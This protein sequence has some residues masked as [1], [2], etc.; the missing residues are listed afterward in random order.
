VEVNY[1]P[2]HVG[3]YAA[4][5]AHLEPL[6]DL[7]YRRMLDLYYRTEKALPCEVSAIARLT[8]LS[9]HAATIRDVLNEFFTASDDG[10]HSK[11]AD[12]ELSEM[13]SKQEQQATKDEHEAERLRRHRARRA[14]MFEAL[15]AVGVIPAWDVAIKELQRLFDT[16]CN[17]PATRTSP[18]PATD[19]QRLSLP[20]PTPTPEVKTARKRAASPAVECPEG[21]DAQVWADWL[22]L[23][24]AKRAP[25]TATTI[26]G[27]TTEAAKA[28]M[29]LDAFLRVWCRRGSQGLE[30]EWLKPNERGS[31]TGVTVQV[32]PQ[33]DQTQDYLA[34]QAEHAANAKGPSP[35]LLAKLRGA[36]KAVA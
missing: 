8:R 32:N 23:R 35:E 20:T 18:L 12:D 28:G 5:T 14:E 3:D 34:R 27:A 15:R 1:Y 31:Q 25:V 2:F 17:A 10:W 9:D 6:E 16:H 33:V 26:A 4:H 19:S 29:S 36:L 22:A 7:A 13:R 21:V 30:A 11:R 24:K